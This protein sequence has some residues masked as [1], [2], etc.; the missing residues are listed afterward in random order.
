MCARN[1]WD[2]HCQSFAQGHV[3]CQQFCF[4][5]HALGQLSEASVHHNVPICGIRGIIALAVLFAVIM[6][7]TPNIRK[8]VRDLLSP[9]CREIKLALMLFAGN[10]PSSWCI[11]VGMVLLNVT[12]FLESLQ[13]VLNSVHTLLELQCYGVLDLTRTLLTV[14]QYCK[15]NEVTQFSELFHRMHFGALYLYSQSVRLF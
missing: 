13:N 14:I 11:K 3:H 2:G 6:E 12:F 8:H 4:I 10:L 15:L 7:S 5:V 9:F 1:L